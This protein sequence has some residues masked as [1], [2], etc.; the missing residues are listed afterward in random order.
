MNTE[1]HGKKKPQKHLPRKEGQ[2]QAEAE[3]L[4]RNDTEKHGRKNKQKQSHGIKN[5]QMICYGMTRN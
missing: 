4:P 2:K 5:K 3:D 1:K